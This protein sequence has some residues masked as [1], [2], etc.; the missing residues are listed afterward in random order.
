MKEDKAQV[1]NKMEMWEPK[2]LNR[3]A[4]TTI[5]PGT[6][7]HLFNHVYDTLKII[8]ELIRE[9]YAEVA[10]FLPTRGFY[11]LTIKGKNLKLKNKK[12]NR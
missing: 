9:G 8:Q 5:I 10:I 1:L 11:R 7:R 12:Q 2:S 4:Y 3:L 6:K